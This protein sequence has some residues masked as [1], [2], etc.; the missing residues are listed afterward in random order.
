MRHNQA[1][2]IDFFNLFNMLFL[3]FLGLICL[4]PFVHILA[5]SFSSNTA[6]VSGM[7]RFW[8]IDFT[9]KSYA[10]V[11]QKQEFLT[12]LIIALERVALGTVI[13]MT[14]TVLT[15]YP[16]SKEVRAFRYRTVFAWFFV[17]TILFNGGLIPWY[18]TISKLG[19]INSILALVLP[20]AVQV[21][22]VILT[23]N[24]FRA[25]PKEMEEAAFADGAGHWSVLFRIFIPVSVPVLATVL[26][27][28]MVNHWN[29][30]FDGLILMNSPSKYPLQTYLYNIIVRSNFNLIDPTDMKQLMD[31][32]E[33]TVKAAQIIVGALPILLVYPFLQ[34]YFMKGIILGSVK[35]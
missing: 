31:I 15:A 27:F 4:L 34:K 2:R 3:A 28:T 9:L 32:N 26:L 19:M 20:G 23:L 11:L 18:I 14:L 1:F 22:H 12:S 5:I 24:F 13:N 7:V 35:E 33:R 21:F 30:W 6:A 8:P 29:A 25:L 17:F 16:L 10:Y